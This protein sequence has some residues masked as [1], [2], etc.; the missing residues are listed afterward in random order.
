M[1]KQI[2]NDIV[3]KGYSL[4]YKLLDIKQQSIGSYSHVITWLFLISSF[5]YFSYRIVKLKNNLDKMYFFFFLL[6]HPI[7]IARSKS[8]HIQ[9][10]VANLFNHRSPFSFFSYWK[11]RYLSLKINK[12][13]L[14]LFR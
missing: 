8:T 10:F 3:S 6:H 14:H 1:H 11:I 5:E 4:I 9:I 13:V 2:I 7:L 12:T